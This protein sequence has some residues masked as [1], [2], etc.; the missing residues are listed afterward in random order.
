MN[1][2]IYI[3]TLKMHWL[4]KNHFKPMHFASELV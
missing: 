3:N 4:K 1:S 2:T